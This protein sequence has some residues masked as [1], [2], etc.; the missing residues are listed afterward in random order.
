[1]N[2]ENHRRYSN[3]SRT[4]FYYEEEREKPF[5]DAL[6]QP[7]KTLV[8]I[9]T[10]GDKS[11]KNEIDSGVST[12]IQ[13]DQ[14]YNVALEQNNSNNATKSLDNRALGNDRNF[15]E[16]FNHRCSQ[17]DLMLQTPNHSS[18]GKKKQRSVVITKE[19][20]RGRHKLVEQQRRKSMNKHIAKLRELMG[21]PMLLEGRRFKKNTIL[22]MACEHIEK[23]NTHIVMLNQQIANDLDKRKEFIN[24][25]AANVVPQSITQND[26]QN[27]CLIE[28]R[29]LSSTKRFTPP[30]PV[31]LHY[32]QSVSQSFEDQ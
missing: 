32:F 7:C 13:V 30:N 9:P 20:Q 14:A 16:N 28:S 8:E 4:L 27:I 29:H 31:T 10:G 18:V 6:I 12:R 22:E 11:Q 23:L 5:L 24:H 1:M 15:D 3:A 25:C 2:S 21:L 26:S 17:L 19:E